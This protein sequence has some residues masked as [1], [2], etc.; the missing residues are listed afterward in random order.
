MDVKICT[1][2][3]TDLGDLG[4]SY[5]SKIHETL[6]IFNSQLPILPLLCTTT[7]G[8]KQRLVN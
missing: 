6:S 7:M 2:L 1:R 8:K 4:G 5:G 3:V